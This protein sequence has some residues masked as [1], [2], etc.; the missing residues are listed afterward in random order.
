[1]R[2]FAARRNSP[3]PLHP[4][5]PRCTVP[6]VKIGSL[7]TGIGGI[8]LGLKAAGVQVDLAW[9]AEQDE[10]LSVIR[11]PGVDYDINLGDV[12]T[13]DWWIQEEVEMITAGFPCQSVS[14]A[15]SRRVEEDPR[16]LWPEVV[17]AVTVHQPQYV[18]CENVQNL[19]YINDGQVWDQIGWDLNELGYGVRYIILGA[20]HVGCTHHRHR[21]FFLATKGEEGVQMLPMSSCGI[22]GKFEPLPTPTV[23]SYLISAS[24]RNRCAAGI[25]RQ[26][27]RYGPPPVHADRVEFA[28]WMMCLPHGHV[29]GRLPS[30]KALQAI[31][32]AVCPPQMAEA[33]RILGGV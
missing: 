29:S 9:V 2:V 4:P 14:S 7:F 30:S 18:L 16:W 32:N 8:E 3:K 23:S 20:C 13:V 28:E 22:R 12:T 17:R 26:A 24:D 15:G 11:L 25:E 31:G 19:V 27:S 6:R 33:W 21:V 1:M 5:L 10:D